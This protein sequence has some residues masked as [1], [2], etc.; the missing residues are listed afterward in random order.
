MRTHNAHLA[1]SF[2]SDGGL[3]WTPVTLL[4]VEN[5]QSGT[6]AVTLRDGRHVLIYNNF[7][8]LPGEKKGPRTPLS[9]AVSS[10]GLAWSH[11]LTLEDSASGEFSYPAIIQ[12]SDGTLHC[13]YTWRRQRVAY[14][15]VALPE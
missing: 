8:T 11:W 2:S 6:D 4:Q 7:Q 15:Q 10:D 12:G 1:T 3:T 5:N 9:L 13:T 14:K